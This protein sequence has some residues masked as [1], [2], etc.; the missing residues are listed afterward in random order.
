VHHLKTI[1]EPLALVIAREMPS[2]SF[3][4]EH[5]IVTR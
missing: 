1:G 2:G 4:V 5:G 3:A